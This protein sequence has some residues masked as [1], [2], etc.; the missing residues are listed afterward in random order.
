MSRHSVT[1]GD[2]WQTLNT[3]REEQ[4]TEKLDGPVFCGSREKKI[5]KKKLDMVSIQRLSSS[6][7]LSREFHTSG[8]HFTRQCRAKNSFPFRP[9]LK[10]PLLFFFFFNNSFLEERK[11]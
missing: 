11:R 10:T 7:T 8:T 9:A 4:P 1:H 5:Q 6:H 3:L 2:T